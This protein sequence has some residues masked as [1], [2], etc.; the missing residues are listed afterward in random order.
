MQSSHRGLYRSSNQGIFGGVCAG[1]ADYFGQPAWLI[2]ILMLTLFVFSGSL[3]VIVYLAALV[4]LDK[5]PT[6]VSPRA[7]MR[8]PFTQTSQ[9]SVR[10]M[11]L[12]MQAL[13]RRLQR[14]ERYV[15]SKKFRFD[16]E[17]K[18]L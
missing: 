11:T 16:Q 6:Q 13:D 10:E 18:D 14:M 3:G 7:E 1:V 5:Q 15:T 4:L 9:A 2:R 17:F 8:N 12:R